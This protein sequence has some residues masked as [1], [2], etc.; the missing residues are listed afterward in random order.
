MY[1]D[2]SDIEIDNLIIKNMEQ[3]KNRFVNS[4]LSNI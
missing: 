3:A 2:K 4:S 1:V